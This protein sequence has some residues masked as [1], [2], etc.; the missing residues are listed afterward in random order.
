MCAIRG[1]CQVN[2][3][4]FLPGDLASGM[5]EGVTT[6]AQHSSRGRV[7]LLADVP[8][9]DA[10]AGHPDPVC[11][12]GPVQRGPQHMFADR[13]AADIAAADDAHMKEVVGHISIVADNRPSNRPGRLSEVT[14]HPTV[15]SIT[16]AMWA[17]YPRALAEDWDTGIG[18]TCGDPAA[19]V[20]TVLFAVDVDDSTVEQ[21]VAIGAELLITHHPL[22]FSAVK[23]VAADTPK[24]RL[25]HRMVQAGVAHFAAHTNADRARG[26]VNDALAASL[27]LIDTRS[28]EPAPMVPMDKL[29]VYVP[30][31]DAPALV[32]ALAAAGAGSFG[33]YS[34]AAFLTDG[35][36]QFRPLPGAEPSI[37]EIDQLERL[38]ET[39]I[40]MFLL[41]QHRNQVVMALR[42]AHPYEEPGFDITEIAPLPEPGVGLG[43]IGQLAKPLPL[44]V[45]V[46]R[47]AQNLPVTA[48]GVLATGDPDRM[49][50]TVAVCGGAGGSLL[51][52]VG[53]ADAYVTADLS[54]H[55]AAEF[56]AERSRPALIQVA[57]WAS[58][59]PWLASAAG[60]VEAA[61]PDRIRSVISRIRTDAW[62]FHL[63]G[64][65]DLG[66]EDRF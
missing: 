60:V 15:G 62:A 44:R 16:A 22:L 59:W 7:G 48:A 30:R 54:H 34:D 36:G 13:R 39:R 61:H 32:Q 63:P 25:I 5:I 27:G 38:P 2:G 14:T 3:L 45:F 1:Q 51:E 56:I 17:A 55:T 46:A 65:L 40:D 47:V 57:H 28:I 50:S 26:G 53:A 24:G 42:A 12:S 35:I 43:R 11:Q 8:V 4:Q 19:P 6:G 64:S 41:R 66:R 18:L 21:A 33:H 58:E 49:I 9:T 29:V 31:A 10:G 20:K 23:S 52:R 37:G